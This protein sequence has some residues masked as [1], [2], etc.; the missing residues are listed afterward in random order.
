[1]WNMDSIGIGGSRGGVG[2]WEGGGRQEI[3]AESAARCQRCSLHTIHDPKRGP[4]SSK[5]EAG[6]FEPKRLLAPGVWM[7]SSLMLMVVRIFLLSLPRV[8]FF[9]VVV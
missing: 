9:C 3:E 8:C 4:S 6:V 2:V 1:M 7:F 5:I